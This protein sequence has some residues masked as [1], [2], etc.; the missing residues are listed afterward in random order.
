M[1]KGHLSCS[2]S[3]GIRNDFEVVYERMKRKEQFWVIVTSVTIHG[4]DILTNKFLFYDR[5]SHFMCSNSV[6]EVKGSLCLQ[7]DNHFLIH[8]WQS[9]IC[10]LEKLKKIQQFQDIY[11]NI[12]NLIDSDSILINSLR[13]YFYPIIHILNFA[14]NKTNHLN[15]IYASYK[16]K[17]LP[18]SYTISKIKITKRFITPNRYLLFQ[19]IFAQG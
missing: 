10:V 16:I 6:L 5:N 1:L 3:S 4:E 15:M 9:L 11:L 13:R 14:K 17:L 2:S 19:I 8:Y 7:L 12:R 18:R